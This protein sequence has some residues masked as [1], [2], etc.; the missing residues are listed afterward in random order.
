MSTKNKS[1]G[2]LNIPYIENNIKATDMEAIFW[3]Q[4]IAGLDS[5]QLQYTQT[6]NL[7]FPG[8]GITGK[9][10][11]VIWPHITVNTLRKV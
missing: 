5:L 10:I 8:I 4:Q 11:P 7:V 3:I 6:I 9:P 2:I 1:G